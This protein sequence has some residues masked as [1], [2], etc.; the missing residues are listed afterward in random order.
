MKK[1]WI[2]AKRRGMLL[3][4]QPPRGI[5]VQASLRLLVWVGGLSA[6]IVGLT[7]LGRGALGIPSIFD[8][9]AWPVWFA[10][11]DAATIV[12][13]LLRAATLAAAWY[14]LG[15]TLLGVVA[16][17]LRS[18]RLVAAS[19][20]LA[21]PAVRR[22]LQ[23]AL[24]VGLATAALGAGSAPTDAPRAMTVA[25]AQPAE[26]WVEMTPL[27]PDSAILVPVA[28]VPERAPAQAA[29]QEWTVRPGE[30]FWSIAETVL[31]RATG[32]R[33]T[34]EEVA[35]YWQRLVAANRSRLPDRGNPDLLYPGQTLRLPATAPKTR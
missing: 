13:A 6:A 18:A 21:V 1:E 2:H 30:H 5:K 34:D 25:A 27:E 12:F 10:R 8:L 23:S 15:T 3:L 22:L 35:E 33:P 11:R 29:P 26:D 19:D 7:A 24:G 17:G 31:R 16:R 9:P 32:A 14:L 20:V 28:P 4:M